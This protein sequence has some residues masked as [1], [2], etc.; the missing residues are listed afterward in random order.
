MNATWAY[1]TSGATPYVASGLT[2]SGIAVGVARRRELV[3]RWL[4]WVCAAVLLGAAAAAGTDGRLLL[5]AGLAV[6]CVREYARLVRMPRVDAAVLGLG[7]LLSLVVAALRPA[8]AG[9]LF[10]LGHFAAALPLIASLP[11][12]LEGDVRRGGRRAAYLTF[13]LLWIGALTGLVSLG[14]HALAL[15]VAVSVA[16]VGAWCAGQALR[17]P[18]L[19][20]LSPGKRVSG[21]AGGAVSGVVVLLLLGAATPGFVVAVALAAPLGDL[22]ESMLKREAGV[23]DAGR[24]LP[25]FGGMLDRVDSLLF[26]LA[27]ALVAPAGLAGLALP[28]GLVLR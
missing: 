1:A 6:P 14:P 27:V 21:M 17:G 5:A 15:V 13:G 9:D 23:K 12:V 11:A 7:V 19:S 22:A 2:L 10:P 3:R 20:P 8:P 25:G 18:H 16:D 4:V 26:A 24:W 28:A